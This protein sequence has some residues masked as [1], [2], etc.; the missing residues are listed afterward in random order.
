MDRSEIKRIAIW[1]LGLEGRSVFERR[2][3]LFPNLEACDFIDENT[4]QSLPA[5][6][7]GCE[8]HQPVFL[9]ESAIDLLIRSAGV[10]PY[11]AAIQAYLK[12]GGEVTSIPNLWFD[13]N[14]GVK[15]V[16]VTGTKGKSTVSKL[17][18]HLLNRLGVETEIGGNI[19]TPMLALPN[20]KAWYVLEMSSYQAA[21]FTG[22]PAM[23]CLLNL[24]EDHVSWH[25]SVSQ[26][27]QDKV[28]LIKQADKGFVHHSLYCHSA[29]SNEILVDADVIEDDA[30]GFELKEAGVF[31]KGELIDLSQLSLK[32]A[33]NHS[34]L[35]FAMRVVSDV[36]ESSSSDVCPRDASEWSA[37]L[38]GFEPLPYRLEEI[39]VVKGRLCVCDPLSTNASSTIASLETYKG[40][41][42]VLI[43]GGLDRSQDLSGLE[44][45]LKANQSNIKII[46][47][48]DTGWKIVDHVAHSNKAAKVDSI[49]AAVQRAFEYEGVEVVLFSPASASRFSYENFKTRGSAFNEACFR[50]EGK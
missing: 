40:K 5:W 16:C 31:F 47:L 12:A 26:Y 33:H 36:L 29:L 48:P 24:G 34:N 25:G 43:L 11:K 23:A 45:Y 4:D 32:G 27:H 21:D 7:E 38:R 15:A 39:G 1:G 14:P 9:Q 42:L 3:K 20:G 50:E 49:E 46:G 10:S 37:L 8:V 18:W 35:L 6:A 13:L 44:A 19:G 30:A 41:S 2:F 22:K 17:I 28:N